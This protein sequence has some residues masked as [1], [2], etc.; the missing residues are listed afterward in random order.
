MPSASGARLGRQRRGHR[1][2]RLRPK[3][4]QFSTVHWTA[5]AGRYSHRL[6]ELLGRS[7]PRNARWIGSRFHS[8]F[9]APSTRREQG[10]RAARPSIREL[11]EGSFR[12]QSDGAVPELES[13]RVGIE[14]REREGRRLPGPRSARRRFHVLAAY[15]GGAPDGSRPIRH[16]RGGAARSP[17]AGQVGRVCSRPP[18][19]LKE[20]PTRPN[21][22][23]PVKG[24]SS[25]GRPDASCQR[26]CSRRRR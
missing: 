8:K 10:G 4:E 9:I 23:A 2:G 1:S 15:R 6:H 7:P 22:R 25:L 5:C 14:S 16:L 17:P 21:G 26:R 24:A 18:L 20:C 3:P 11:V 19:S 13:T 12:L